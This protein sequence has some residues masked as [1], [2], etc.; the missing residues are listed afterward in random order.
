[1]TTLAELSDDQ[2]EQMEPYAFF[3]L[4]GKRVIH[5]GGL[6]STQKAYDLA[7]VGK[8]DHVLEVGCGVGTTSIGLVRRTG[9]RVTAVDIDPFMIE[10][11]KR[12][13]ADAKLSERITVAVGDIL[14]LRHPDASFDAVIIETVT[15]FVDHR[16]AVKEVMRVCRPGGRIVDHEFVWRATP[17]DRVK[18]VMEVQLCPSHI[19]TPEELTELYRAA[20]LGDIETVS[21][22]PT[23]MTALGMLR[24][25]GP[26]NLLRMG[27]RVLSR[28]AN[29]KKVL[30]I[31]AKFLEAFPYLGWVVL[32]GTKQS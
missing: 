30:S 8:K 2:I 20:G 23:I 6:L 3:A 25:E 21:G 26:L 18:N 4:I 11:A 7:S 12:N 29:V 22:I 17:T 14:A 15:M 9:C 10:Q 28:R 31:I 16:A 1:M 5:P 19:N 13:V 24:D 27:E 32:G